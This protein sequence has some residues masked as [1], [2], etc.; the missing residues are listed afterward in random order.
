MAGSLKTAFFN[1]VKYAANDITS[2]LTD[3]NGNMDKIDT[4]LNQNKTAVQTAQ[5]GVDNLE[6]EYK[7]VVQTLSQ[8][9][10]DIDATEKAIAENSASIRELGKDVN[11]INI[12]DVLLYGIDSEEITKIEPLITSF[13]ICGRRIGKDFSGSFACRISNGTL[14]NY[15]RNVLIDGKSYYCRDFV[16]ITGNPFNLESNIV[17]P[18]VGLWIYLNATEMNAGLYFGII[19]LPDSG[20]TV[21]GYI[22]NSTSEQTFTSQTNFVAIC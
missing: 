16:R 15:D 10:I 12:G 8:H 17:T 21:I 19:Y 22:S 1:L 11:N 6:S 3:F 13:N 14:H 7:S 2:W 5:D 18:L 20:Y 4:A 9:T